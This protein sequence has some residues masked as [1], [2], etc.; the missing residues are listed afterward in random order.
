MYISCDSV[1]YIKNQHL[2]INRQIFKF[3]VHTQTEFNLR[4]VVEENRNFGR[5][6]SFQSHTRHPLFSLKF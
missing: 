6:K 4:Q 1:L 2:K 5:I 3:R